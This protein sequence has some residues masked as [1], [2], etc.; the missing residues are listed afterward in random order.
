LQ[1]PVPSDT[2]GNC[3]RWLK[4]FAQDPAQFTAQFTGIPE[5]GFGAADGRITDNSEQFESGNLTDDLVHKATEIEGGVADLP[6]SRL[7]IDIDNVTNDRSSLI[8]VSS[9]GQQLLE[10]GSD[11]GTGKGV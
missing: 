8:H 7:I 3:G 2:R 10:G 6:V 1:K 4:F 5:C 9:A 11:R